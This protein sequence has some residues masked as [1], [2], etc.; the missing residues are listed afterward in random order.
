[1][2]YRIYV[3]GALTQTVDSKDIAKNQLTEFMN[4]WCEERMID[5]EDTEIHPWEGT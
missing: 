1:M 3:D 2:K 5:V 4:K